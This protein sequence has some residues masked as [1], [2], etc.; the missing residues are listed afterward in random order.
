MQSL[1]ATFLI[2][3]S[4]TIQRLSLPQIRP[5][6]DMVEPSHGY[7]WRKSVSA[8]M[9]LLTFVFVPVDKSLVLRTIDPSTGII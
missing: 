5:S 1:N 8:L 4:R 9:E 7:K 6:E 3:W 2:L